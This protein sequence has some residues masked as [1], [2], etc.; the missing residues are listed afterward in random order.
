ML[1]KGLTV[2]K[3]CVIKPRVIRNVKNCFS[4]EIFSVIIENATPLND[5]GSCVVVVT[6]NSEIHVQSVKMSNSMDEEKSVIAGL[7]EA[8]QMLKEM[9][10]YPFEYP[11]SFAHMNLECPKGILLQG[12]PG[13]GKTLLVRT[14]TGECNAQLITI[15]GTDVFGPHS[16]ESEDNLRKVFEKAR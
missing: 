15:N 1:L 13:V 2:V 12:V 16:G 14:V 4:K 9:L 11:E 6:E 7:D 3:G 5:D 10:K 8:S